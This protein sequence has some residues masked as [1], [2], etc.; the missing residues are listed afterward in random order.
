M[1]R[2]SRERL[3]MRNSFLL[4]RHW[5]SASCLP[6]QIQ[7]GKKENKM[8]THRLR[9]TYLIVFTSTSILHDY[10]ECNEIYTYVLSQ[11]NNKAHFPSLVRG[12]RG[13]RCRWMDVNWIQNTKM[14]NNQVIIKS[15]KKVSMFC[16]RYSA[17]QNDCTLVSE[18]ECLRL[19][20]DYCFWKLMWGKFDDG[21][22]AFDYLVISWNLKLAKLLN[23]K[24]W[25]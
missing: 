2:N 16:S 10:L 4:P 13:K 14:K 7:Y 5:T 24:I 19:L 20:N 23:W 18:F 9:S 22:N 8:M 1:T 6:I 3:N 15:E 12:Q 11:M 25:W 17:F 21:E